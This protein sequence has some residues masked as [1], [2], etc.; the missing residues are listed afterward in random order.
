MKSLKRPVKNLL[1]CV[2]IASEVF[3]CSFISADI[4]EITTERMRQETLDFVSANL[5]LFRL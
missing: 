4:Y 1:L 2:L 5:K 3:M